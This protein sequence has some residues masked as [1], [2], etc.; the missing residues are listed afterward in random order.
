MFGSHGEERIN[1]PWTTEDIWM[2]KTVTI[3]QEMAEPVIKIA[4]DDDYEVYINGVLVLSGTGASGAYKYIKLDQSQ[5]AALKKGRNTIALHCKNTGGGQHIDMGLGKIAKV[6]P[7]VT[8]IVNTVSQEM[9]YDKTVLEAKAGQIIEIKLVNKDQ[10]PHNLVVIQQGSLDIFG[11][12]V[13]SFV[14]TPDAEK[15]GYV[16]KSRYV[17]GATGMLGP[18]ETGS[19]TVQLPVTPG[20]YPFVCTFPGHW[21]FMQGVIIV[22]AADPD[23]SVK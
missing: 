17:L 3:D 12:L 15:M 8:F 16:P 2:R 23:I 20:R 10:M 4:Y 19:I 7:D 22:S 13:D 14:T 21:R 5:A 1:T 6:K 11:P 18:N 9:A